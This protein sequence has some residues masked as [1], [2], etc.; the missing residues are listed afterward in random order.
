M[1]SEEELLGS[2]IGSLA[3]ANRKTFSA[4]EYIF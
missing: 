1:S 2:Y 4:C 3:A